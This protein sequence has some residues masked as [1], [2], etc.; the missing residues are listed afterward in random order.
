MC[1]SSAHVRIEFISPIFWSIVVT[2]DHFLALT[3]AWASTGFIFS[4][5]VSI[6][7]DL[8]IWL[9]YLG[10]I[11]CKRLKNEYTSSSYQWILYDVCPLSVWMI[12]EG[13]RWNCERSSMIV[14]ISFASGSILSSCSLNF[15]T[16]LYSSFC[17]IF[18]SSENIA[19]AV[20]NAIS[21]FFKDWI[22]FSSFSHF[23]LK[24]RKHRL[25]VRFRTYLY[26]CDHSTLL[27]SCLTSTPRR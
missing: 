12:C 18:R 3:R 25:M 26:H 2:F 23:L 17:L 24:A 9:N 6:H 19:I 16:S 27:G 15:S 11:R 22:F 13:A 10:A 20:S 1:A 14:S 5:D 21:S 4:S 7:K 8:P